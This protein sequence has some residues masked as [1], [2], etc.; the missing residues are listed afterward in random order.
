MIDS[1]AAGTSPC[2]LMGRVLADVLEIRRRAGPL[3]WCCLLHVL[4]GRGRLVYIIHLLRIKT[5]RVHMST[6]SILAG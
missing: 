4:G 2:R 6:V 3:P 1:A 5:P